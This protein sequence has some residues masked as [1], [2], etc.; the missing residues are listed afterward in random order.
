MLGRDLPT[1]GGHIIRPRESLALY[2]SFNT[3]CHLLK[4]VNFSL[5]LRYLRIKARA[6]AQ[7]GPGYEPETVVDAEL[8]FHHIVV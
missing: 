3:L 4:G 5:I 1:P 8:I 6:L 2:N 7:E